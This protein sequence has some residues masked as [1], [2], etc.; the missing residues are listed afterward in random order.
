MM[1]TAQMV[2]T[3]Y[4][5]SEIKKSMKIMNK[6]LKTINVKV[7]E[8]TATNKIKLKLWGCENNNIKEEILVIKGSKKDLQKIFDVK[9]SDGVYLQL[10]LE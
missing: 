4:D 9:I 10:L 2:L 6:Y 5:K 1:R 8:N 3:G 7:I